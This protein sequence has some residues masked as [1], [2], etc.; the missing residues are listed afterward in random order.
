[1]KKTLLSGALLIPI[2]VIVY[3]SAL[4]FDDAKALE[5]SNSNLQAADF[6]IS[7]FNGANY[8]LEVLQEKP[9][10]INFW[11][12]WCEPCNNEAPLLVDLYEQYG[13]NVEFYGINTTDGEL[14]IKDAKGFTDKFNINF[15]VL[16]DI[17][18]RVSKEYG[19]I[20]LPTTYFID[21][22]GVIVDKI[23][24]EASKEIFEKRI[25]KLIKDP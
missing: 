17:E 18:G 3:L 19:V 25:K 7:N 2:I 5:V 9:L 16:L 6:N 24:G 14:K 13:E 8:S 10:I 22:N 23:L 12:S 11:A 4:D 20:A 15:P 1:M 21:Q